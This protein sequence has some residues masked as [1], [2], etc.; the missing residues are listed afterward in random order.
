MINVNAKI[1][2]KVD[3]SMIDTDRTTINSG[4]DWKDYTL[5]AKYGNNVA[6][7][8]NVTN[9]TYGDTTTTTPKVVQAKWD[10]NKF[11][12]TPL[13]GVVDQKIHLEFDATDA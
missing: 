11:S 10:N 2:L 3:T 4:T 6:T 9:I 5:S 8:A 7:I 12:I 1:E 13:V